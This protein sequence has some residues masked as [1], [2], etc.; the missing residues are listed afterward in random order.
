MSIQRLRKPQ[1]TVS[2]NTPSASP[3]HLHQSRGA[4]EHEPRQP[5]WP[6][7]NNLNSADCFIE[8]FKYNFIESTF[9]LNHQFVDDVAQ[10]MP[11]SNQQFK[12]SI[13]TYASTNA[14]CLGL[15]NVMMVHPLFS[16]HINCLILYHTVCT[17][18]K[19]HCPAIAP[20]AL[21]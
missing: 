7:H 13:L 17:N 1:P 5:H 18:K 6:T 4:S 9:W 21:A 3:A 15:A 19:C 11:S 10:H 2:G 16:H 20:S 8:L 12:Y 14:L